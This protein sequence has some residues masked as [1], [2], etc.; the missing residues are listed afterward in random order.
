[1]RLLLD[2]H[3]LLWFLRNSPQLSFRALAAIESPD[4][5]VFISMVCVWEIA[6][7]TSLGKLVLASDFESMFPFQLEANRIEVL[8]IQFDDLH[9]L[10]KLP[11]HHRDP[12]DRMILVQAMTNKLTLISRDTQF[13]KYGV[14]TL[15]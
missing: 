9:Q 15:L 1:M 8:P 3:A 6:I 14:P 2:T 13:E 4:S 10:S 5:R 12:F 11:F 7:K